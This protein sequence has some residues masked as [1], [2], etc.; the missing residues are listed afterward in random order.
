MSFQLYGDN[1]VCI[2][3]F[4]HVYFRISSMLSGNAGQK[5]TAVPTQPTDH[6]GG[7]F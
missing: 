2:L 7:H 4:Q 3:I 1:V 5:Q 6:E